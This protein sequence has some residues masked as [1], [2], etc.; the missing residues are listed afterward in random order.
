MGPGFRQDDSGR[1]FGQF[2]AAFDRFSASAL[3]IAEISGRMK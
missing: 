1:K 3:A 2:A